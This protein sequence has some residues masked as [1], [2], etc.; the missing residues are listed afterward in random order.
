MIHQHQLAHI[1]PCSPSTLIEFR[2]T[3]TEIPSNSLHYRDAT[4]HES[5]PLICNSALNRESFSN[6]SPLP[7]FQNWRWTPP[8]IQM[9]I[10]CLESSGDLVLTR[11]NQECIGGIALESNASHNHVGCSTLLPT[12]TIVQHNL[13]DNPSI[14]TWWWC[15][16]WIRNKTF[17]SRGKQN[18][19]WTTT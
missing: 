17:G 5:N 4:S 11:G 13:S 18:Q 8:Q 6:K 14:L 19:N 12:K 16:F 2:S 7:I 1:T 10:P 3:Q 15:W 9:M